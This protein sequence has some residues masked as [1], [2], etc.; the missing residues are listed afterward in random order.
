MNRFIT[1]AQSEDPTAYDPSKPLPKA[2][3]VQ[4]DSLIVSGPDLGDW[5]V[6]FTETSEPVADQRR[7]LFNEWRDSG[8]PHSIVG[9]FIVTSHAG[10]FQTDGRPIVKVDM[11][12]EHPV[13]L[14]IPTQ[15]TDLRLEGQ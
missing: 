11:P 2:F 12:G 15:R 9:M 1:L 3:E 7:V 13:E 5:L 6:A 8:D 10:T 4:L 14:S